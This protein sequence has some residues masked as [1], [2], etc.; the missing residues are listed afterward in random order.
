[1]YQGGVPERFKID[2]SGLRIGNNVLAIKILNT[3]ISSSDLSSIV[4]LHGKIDSDQ[5]IYYETPEWFNEPVSFES[6]NLPIVKIYTKGQQILDDP[7]IDAHMGIIY[8]E[9]GVENN[10][11]DSA[12]NFYGTIGIEIRGQST[13]LYPKKSFGFETRD[14][15]GQNLNVSLLG[16]PEEND[17]ILY[18]P[19]ADKSLLRNVFTFEIAKKLKRYSSKTVLCELIINDEYQGIYVLMEKIKRD[20]NRVDIAKLKV[21]ETSGDDLTGGYIFKVDK[22]DPDYVE[23][24]SGFKSTPNPTYPNAMDITY[25]YVYPKAEDLAIEQNNYLKEYIIEAE[26]TLIHYNFSNPNE[27]YNKY[28]NTGSFVDFLLISELCKGVDKYRYSTYF[29]KKKE[30][31][32]NEI[33]AGP[34]WDFNFAYANVDYWPFGLE[35]EG[36]LYHQVESHDWSI[37]FWWKRLMEDDFFESLVTSRWKELRQNEFSNENLAATFDS[38]ANIVAHAQQRN[39]EKWP[40]L[41]SYVWPNYNWENNTYNDEV[42]YFSNWVFARLDWMDNNMF[43]SEL[44]P[45]ALM[46]F[47]NYDNSTQILK[48]K[49]SLVDDCFNNQQLKKKH[50]DIIDAPDLFSVLSV[51]YYNATTAHIEIEAPNYTSFSGQN[52]ILKL[53]DKTLNGFTDVF[54]NTMVLSVDN[55]VNNSYCDIYTFKNNLL[56]NCTNPVLLPN[57]ITIYNAIGQVVA[58]YPLAKQQRNE[59]SLY[60]NDNIYI[61]K[62]VFDGKVFA[63]KIR[64]K[65]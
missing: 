26:K 15:L 1:M 30:S 17:W 37:M 22:I 61:A 21:E 23:G 10:V 11:I 58:S 20:E 62:L 2:T 31:N 65:N 13:Q 46:E 42:N 50:F 51:N 9:D 27:G 29:H 3:D 57:E 54:T 48:L 19:Y 5:T 33:F 39:Y 55:K 49:V 18:A 52:L 34:I 32:G 8:N 63:K 38:L 56:L 25:Q 60:L 59:I 43:G 45:V 53:S 40:V 7:K 6:S 41:G 16:M 47:V 64:V 35:A 44:Y 14:S 12:N 36:W 28:L 24:Y 4:F